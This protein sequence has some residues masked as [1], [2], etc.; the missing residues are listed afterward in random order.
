MKGSWSS[1]IAKTIQLPQQFISEFN[2]EKI[3]KSVYICFIYIYIYH[4]NKCPT[5]VI[6]FF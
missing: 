5:L 6:L 1:G 2:S 3:T 4:K